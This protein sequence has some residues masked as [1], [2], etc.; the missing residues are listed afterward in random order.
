MTM[1]QFKLTK[2]LGIL[3]VF[4]FIFQTIA[5]VVFAEEQTMESSI[6]STSELRRND[7]I[8]ATSQSENQ[9]GMELPTSES[10]MKEDQTKSAIKTSET[11]E[12]DN[13]KGGIETKARTAGD[14]SEN[15]TI[16]EWSIYEDDENHPIS[17]TN[18][19]KKD[20][21]Y[22][23]QFKWSL[24]LS[25][26]LK[27]EP[28]DFFQLNLLENIGTS[29]TAEGPND[30]WG[31]WMTATT[32]T[33]KRDLVAKIDGTDTTIGKWWIDWRD[34][35]TPRGK[36]FVKV[37]F[38]EGVSGKNIHQITGVEFNLGGKV[39][40][41]S[42]IKGGIQNVIF[43]DKVQRILFEQ[44]QG[45][46]SEGTDYKYCAEPGSNS[47][48]FDI[49]VGRFAP[50]ELSGDNV[51]YETNPSK[52]FYLDGDYHGFNWGEN[53]S[54][55]N[56]L[57]VEDTLDAGVV[58][59]SLSISSLISAPIGLTKENQETQTGGLVNADI[60]PFESFL[61]ADYGNGP[62]FRQPGME[63]EIQYPLQTYSFRLV[64]QNDG[65]S[66]DA[67]RE[68]VK[69]TPHQYGIYT[70]GS[71][72]TAIRTIMMN[73]G[74]VKK[75]GNDQVKY[76]DLT[77]Q[78]YASP[79]RTITRKAG[80]VLGEETVKITQF[81]VEAAEKTIQHGLYEE[82]DR[83]LLEDYYTL[84]YGDSNVIDGQVTA[85]NISMKLLYRLDDDLDE[86][87]ENRAQTYYKNALQQANPSFTEPGEVHGTGQMTNP[88]GKISIN[89]E[90]AALIKFDGAT[91]KEMNNV[92]FELQKYNES[93]KNWMKIGNN[94]T[95]GEVRFANGETV[96][97]AIQVTGLDP[98]SY[99]FVEKAGEG[100]STIYPEGYDQTDAPGW[101]EGEKR[102]ISETIILN[103]VD[104]AQSVKVENI[105]KTTAPYAIQ[106]WTLKKGKNP[107]NASA[108]DFEVLSVENADGAIRKP[109][110]ATITASPRNNILGFSYKEYSFEKK[111]GTIT[112]VIDPNAT[113]DENGQLILKLYYVPDDDAIPFTIYKEGINGK[114]MP[115]YNEKGEPL[116][117]EVSFYIY[118]YIGGWQSGSGPWDQKPGDPNNRCWK[119]V[120][121]DSD[122]NPLQQP[123]KTDSE[124]RIRAKIHLTEDGT[125][126]TGSR[127]LAIVE[128]TNT[129][130]NYV[131]PTVDENWWIIWTG[132][133]ATSPDQSPKGTIKNINDEGSEKAGSSRVEKEDYKSAKITI[134]NKRIKGNM[135][136]YKANQDKNMMPSTDKK[137]VQFE[138][139]EY[140]SSIW[141]DEQNPSNVPLSNGAFWKKLESYQT[142]SKGKIMDYELTSV[143]TYAA[144]EIS[145]YPGYRVPNGFWLLWTSQTPSG[146]VNHGVS[147]VQGNNDDPGAI[148]PGTDWNDKDGFILLN[149]EVRQDF[150]FIK[151]NENG[152]AL[153][154]VEF[155][156]Y[157]RKDDGSGS[158]DD[159]NSLDT[160]WDMSKPFKTAISEAAGSDKG[161]VKFNLPIG[162]YLLVE[163]RTAP[164]YQLPQ[165][166]WILTIDP[167]NSNP[168]QR[169]KIQARGE[170]LPPAF[171]L[172]NGKYHLPNLRSYQLPSSGAAG[173]LLSV[174]IGIVLIGSAF[175]VNGSKNKKKSM[176]K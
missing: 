131:L 144:K 78:E 59:E 73:F 139:Y 28:G 26:G 80:S 42:T 130:P 140:I 8:G 18:P 104:T 102:I 5:P 128:A 55:I 40:K 172:K 25:D 127:T 70:N 37:A 65:E 61:L 52:G 56:N 110:G 66:L 163:T 36:F 64:T 49:G 41:N 95:T 156:L 1:K 132:E 153:G 143:K 134:I 141:T 145:S 27:V 124:S 121:E 117:T 76:S 103:G 111:T 23:F 118:E 58:V 31:V 50:L 7:L 99:R 91:N 173:L 129:Y 47:L 155:M 67:F 87:K 136:L 106:H 15:V 2:G 150:S 46:I 82:K 98:G 63:R 138:L 135:T 51:D 158:S 38:D 57:Y 35:G 24:S 11:Q 123:I 86:V 19:A 160:Y 68:R 33:N 112:E 115:S 97:G 171:Y 157:A 151:E 21:D 79:E 83:A 142:D 43:G 176:N 94:H 170:P 164:G 85:F 53:Y 100:T 154:E 107:D 92:E 6:I 45:R 81:A 168:N 108:D 72:S 90:T 116:E 149:K 125:D 166:Q 48:K 162:D 17:A 126:K 101:N 60:A 13:K 148:E 71:A 69:Q 146:Y 39:L 62:I 75:E 167:L 159:P 22:N 9:L 152:E 105:P 10:L 74:D 114:P 32:A 96:Q 88:Y 12:L 137:Q 165:G 120:E 119:L 161:L 109:I 169:V 174:V 30:G 54:E 29:T 20:T 175:L 122:G 93:S 77:K 113:Y 84:T 89:T 3:T 14:I 4:L 16:S 147:Y 34:D 44:F 133:G